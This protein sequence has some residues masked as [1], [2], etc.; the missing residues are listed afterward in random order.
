MRYD[1]QFDQWFSVAAME[2]MR[3][4]PVAVALPG[5]ECG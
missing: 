4:G 5:R 1:P 2:I 3:A